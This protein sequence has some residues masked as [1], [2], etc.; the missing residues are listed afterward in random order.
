MTALPTSVAAPAAWRLLG[1][2]GALSVVVQGADVL[3][4]G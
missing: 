1:F 2:G 4:A 3:H